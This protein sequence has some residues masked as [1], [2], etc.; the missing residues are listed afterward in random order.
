MFMDQFTELFFKGENSLFC[1][2]DV[3]YISGFSKSLAKER[4]SV[5]SSKPLRG[6]QK[7]ILVSDLRQSRRLVCEPLKA[8]IKA[9]TT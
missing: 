1:R 3:Q 5:C 6:S 2:G 9:W 7:T 8:V 4:K